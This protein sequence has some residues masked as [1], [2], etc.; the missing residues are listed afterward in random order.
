[1]FSTLSKTE[2]TIF[3]TFNLI[4]C[5]CF[6]FGLVQNFV[7]WEWINSDGSKILSFGEEF[8]L[9]FS[10]QGVRLTS[11]LDEF[12]ELDSAYEPAVKTLSL[13]DKFLFRKFTF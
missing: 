7:V 3:V 1:M 8:M 11:S 6:Q 10:I 5:K 9:G 13:K 4:V 2:I 12:V